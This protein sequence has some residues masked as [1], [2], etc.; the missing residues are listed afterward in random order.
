MSNVPYK[1]SIYIRFC[2]KWDE[3]WKSFLSG[4]WFANH[5]PFFISLEKSAWLEEIQPLCN[6]PETSLIVESA[7]SGLV[8]GGLSAA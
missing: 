8:E 4:E 6:K 7:M 1:K 5:S 2:R 3:I